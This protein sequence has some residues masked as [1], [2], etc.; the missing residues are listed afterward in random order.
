[1]SDLHPNDHLLRS[2]AVVSDFGLIFD[3]TCI[4]ER[5]KGDFCVDYSH[6][7][8]IVQGTPNYLPPELLRAH[9]NRGT[10]DYSKCDVYALSVCMI[11]MMMRTPFKPSEYHRQ[12]LASQHITVVSHQ[13][14]PRCSGT[15]TT[16]VG[17]QKPK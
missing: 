9:Q 2:R 12:V 11:Q 16:S 10:I 8:A 15:Q 17:V 13:H 1:M 4:S 7:D 5:K 3:R 14:Q 6:P